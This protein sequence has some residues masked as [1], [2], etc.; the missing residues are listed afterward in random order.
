MENAQTNDNPMNDTLTQTDPLAPADSLAAG[1]DQTAQTAPASSPANAAPADSGADADSAEAA[2]PEAAPVE[3]AA[4]EAAPVE[5]AAVEAAA[6]PIEAAPAPAPAIRES[7]TSRQPTM[8]DVMQSDAYMTGVDT[9]RPGSL[10]KGT[11]VRIDENSGE[12][13]VDIGAKSEGIIPRDEV[14]HEEINVGDEIEVVVRRSGGEEEDDHPIL[15]KTRADYKRLWRELNQAKI[16]QTALEGTVKEQVKGG[17]IVDLGVPAFVP[18]RY[19]DTR[20]KGDLSRFVGRVIPVKILEIDEKRSKVIAS[21]RAA[22]EED[23]K[24]REAT[25]WENLEKDKIIEGVVQRITDFGAFIDLGGIDGLLHVREMSWGRVE[26]PSHV[27]KKG[28]KL[29]VVILEIDE[30]RK[31]IALGLKQL[32]PDPW[33]KAAKTYRP[34]QMVPGKVVRMV[35]TCAFIEL[36]EGIEGIIPISEMS[37]NRIK[38][39]EE[40]LT[41]GQEIEA[42]VKSIEPRQRRISLSLKAAVQERERRETRSTVKEFNERGGND[43]VRLGDVFGNALR[44]AKERGKEREKTVVVTRDEKLSRARQ[45]AEEEEDDFG[46][47]DWQEEATEV[48]DEAVETTDDVVEA[49]E[50]ADEAVETT[51]EVVETTADT[52]AEAVESEAVESEAVESEAVESEAVGPDKDI[53]SDSLP[54]AL[55]EDTAT[56]NLPDASETGTPVADN[57]AGDEANSGQSSPAQ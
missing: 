33:K 30:E 26:H 35:P 9:L 25:A 17:L 55:Q 19:V 37:E 31:R 11:V 28:Q 12:V 13:M 39:P 36:E 45:A 6:P 40:V 56:D 20:H 41:V 54:G 53:N 14:G 46:E 1:D 34:G 29:Q 32:Q 49:T 15:S 18:A 16:D 42:R 4:P 22:A 48:A 23:R 5:A 47:D 50:V 2:A 8:A 7:R 51:D 38:T 44:A 27:V 52:T 57:I 10:I 3:A 43:E 24:A 21:H